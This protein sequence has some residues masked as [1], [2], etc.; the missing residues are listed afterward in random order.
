MR[1]LTF[2]HALTPDGI[3]NGV[4]VTVDGDGRIAALGAAPPDAAFDGDF[5]LPALANAHSH[6]FQR[7]LAG[8]GEQRQGKDSFWSWREAMYALANG[9]TPD[10]M[11]ELSHRAFR[12]MLLT[13]FTAVA[14]FHYVH[15]PAP[16]MAD[17][18]IAAARDA[19]IRL[20]L[21]PVYYHAGG[22]GEPARPSQKRFIHDSV[23][24]FLRYVDALD[25]PHLGIAVHSLRAVP[26]EHLR[27]L[28]S[29]R[30][31][32]LFHIHVS[33]QVAEVEQCV[34][35]LGRR[36]V[37]LLAD[38]VELSPCWTLVHATHADAAERRAIRDAGACVALCPLTE[39]Y[40][41]DGLFAATEH[42]RAGGAFALGTDANSRIDVF[43]ELRW[44]EYGQRL[45]DLKRARFSDET[46]LGA[47]LWRAAGEG[48]A[49]ATGFE[50]GRIAPGWFADFAVLGL[51]LAPF[52]GVAPERALDAAVTG[53]SRHAIVKTFIG[54]KEV[55]R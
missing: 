21:L 44:L 50:V 16:A 45:R 31:D 54:G 51:D 4:E 7:G 22:F 28:V 38:S 55:T 25:H 15:Q 43:D 37:E 34:A 24:A 2:K 17:A 23:D 35:A 49:Q 26:L 30:P 46:G 42:H 6:A 14:E 52:A 19:G 20:R 39:A 27:E 10:T 13:G 3:V 11:Y 1:R 29:A 8:L 48:G 5:A 32:A 12:E 33:E 53:A 18:V 47:P 36:P 41:G 40:L 9:L